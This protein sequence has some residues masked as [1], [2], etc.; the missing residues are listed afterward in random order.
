[1]DKLWTSDFSGVP[2]GAHRALALIAIA[3]AATRKIVGVTSSYDD[4][5]LTLRAF[6]ARRNAENRS[7]FCEIRLVDNSG[8]RRA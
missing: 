7:N 3:P 1:V 2:A 5:S 6:I 4:P 8:R